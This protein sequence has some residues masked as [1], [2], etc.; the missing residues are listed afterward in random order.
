MFLIALLTVICGSTAFLTSWLVTLTRKEWRSPGMQADGTFSQSWYTKLISSLVIFAVTPSQPGDG[1][2]SRCFRSLVNK[3]LDN[4]IFC[5]KVLIV[6]ASIETMTRKLRIMPLA[7]KVIYIYDGFVSTIAGQDHI[8]GE[9]LQLLLYYSSADPAAISCLKS[10]YTTSRILFNKNE[11]LPSIPNLDVVFANISGK[12]VVDPKYYKKYHSMEPTVFLRMAGSCFAHLICTI[13]GQGKPTLRPIFRRCD[14]VVDKAEAM[15]SVLPNKTKMDI[16]K[17]GEKH[18]VKSNDPIAF[19]ESEIVDVLDQCDIKRRVDDFREDCR[20]NNMC[21]IKRPV[22]QSR[23][24][25]RIDKKLRENSYVDDI[26]ST[27]PSRKTKHSGSVKRDIVAER[28]EMLATRNFNEYDIDYKLYIAGKCDFPDISDQEIEGLSQRKRTPLYKEK[29]ATGTVKRSGKAQ[30]RANYRNRRDKGAASAKKARNGGWQKNKITSEWILYDQTG[31]V[32]MKTDHLPENYETI[33]HDNGVGPVSE[34]SDDDVNDTYHF[35]GPSWADIMDEEDLDRASKRKHAKLF[36]K[37]EG[38]PTQIAINSNS[39]VTVLVSHCIDD[40]GNRMFK[41]A[42][43]IALNWPDL[44]Q[45]VLT[46]RH[47]L[48][49][50]EPGTTWS[51]A[52]NV[53]IEP[54]S[55]PGWKKFEHSASFLYRCVTDKPVRLSDALLI[56]VPESKLKCLDIKPYDPKRNLVGMFGSKVFTCAIGSHGYLT[57]NGTKNYKYIYTSMVTDIDDGSSGTPVFQYHNGKA[58]VVGI[59]NGKETVRNVDYTRVLVLDFLRLTPRQGSTGGA[60]TKDL[61]VPLLVPM[62]KS[63]SVSDQSPTTSAPNTVTTVAIMGQH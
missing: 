63:K 5:S 46:V 10:A 49:K 7:E 39:F 40:L 35:D 21:D 34:E 25:C 28:I 26:R 6:H 24:D 30:K 33:A 38:N 14:L 2:C 17:T 23:E 29:H 19:V 50:F 32:V 1:L 43:G 31:K 9:V 57:Q 12:I 53:K 20:T 15:A 51:V 56:N 45:C 22:D 3:V 8:T 52:A 59:V 11:T 41:K 16:I 62:A 18:P 48:P 44:G 55:S 61:S 37:P 58:Y 47:I 36:T 42:R 13:D 4:P 54:V 27:F 60:L